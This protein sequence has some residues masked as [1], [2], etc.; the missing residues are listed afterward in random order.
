M[1][2]IE[3]W[4]LRLRFRRV[5]SRRIR[6]GGKGPCY[7]LFGSDEPKISRPVRADQEETAE[8]KTVRACPRSQTRFGRFRFMAPG[9]GRK[10]K[11]GRALV[12]GQTERKDFPFGA[13]P[14]RQLGLDG[15]T[16]S[17]RFAAN[18][19]ARSSNCR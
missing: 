15:G 9:A 1:C 4:P 16:F 17:L 3:N 12:R 2:K 5:S 19:P 7:L 10:K 14:F 11:G 6:A 13:R 8:S 18:W